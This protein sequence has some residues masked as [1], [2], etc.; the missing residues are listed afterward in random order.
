MDE[1]IEELIA[2]ILAEMPEKHSTLHDVVQNIMDEPI[3]DSVKVRL[4]KPCSL[5]NISLHRHHA[6]RRLPKGRQLRRSLILSLVKNPLDL[7]KK[8]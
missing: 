2:E 1:L 8:K 4:L 7:L 5:E 3:P 6:K